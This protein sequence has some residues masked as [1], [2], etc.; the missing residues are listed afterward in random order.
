MAFDLPA[1]YWSEL[2][3]QND[4][5]VEK[6]VRADFWQ[7]GVSGLLP[8]LHGQGVLLQGRCYLVSNFQFCCSGYVSNWRHKLAVVSKGRHELPRRLTHDV[9][10]DHVVA[11][12]YFVPNAIFHGS[13]TIT[14]SFYIW[15]SLIPALIGNIIGGG[16][17]V[18]AAYWCLHASGEGPIS[19]DGALFAADQRT[20]MGQDATPSEASVEERKRSDD[21]V[22]PEHMV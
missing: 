6:G 21:H 7:A 22:G 9:G 10:F 2:V 1:W 3:R 15:K 5:K 8:L 11:N 4:S 16:V 17:F 13:P 14:T 20:L 12:M 18:G 19:V